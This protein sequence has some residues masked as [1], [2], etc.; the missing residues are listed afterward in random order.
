MPY[1]F[2]G[3]NLYHAL[4]K[5]SEALASVT[6]LFM[7]E[8]IAEDMAGLRDKAAIVF[9]GHPLRGQ[10]DEGSTIG[11][12]TIV[13]S[14]SE[15]DADTVL[16]KMIRENTAP[17][18]LIVVSS[19]NRIKRAARRRRAQGVTSQEYIEALLKR[20]SRP[21]RGPT[22]PREKQSG[23]GPGELNEWLD[24]FGLGRDKPPE[25]PL[26]RIRY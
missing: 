26:D 23:L 11:P 20:L 2:D 15:S 1:L 8:L 16:E 7:C 24:L 19:D 14:R 18:R 6:P 9:D 17:R 12:V 4:R 10:F 5:Q 13:H 25:D 21:Q 22:E 3:Y